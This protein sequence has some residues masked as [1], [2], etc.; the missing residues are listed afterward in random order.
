MARSR[1]VRDSVSGPVRRG[2]GLGRGAAAILLLCCAACAP[3][4]PESERDMIG[5]QRALE[6]AEAMLDSRP[7]APAESPDGAA[8][9]ASA[10]PR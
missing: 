7:A 3:R 9:A 1:R 10:S 4:Q 6:R 5:E 8:P 2:V